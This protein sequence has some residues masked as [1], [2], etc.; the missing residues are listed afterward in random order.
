MYSTKSSTREVTKLRALQ[1]DSELQRHEAERRRREG[2]GQDRLG[3]DAFSV[4][5]HP[6]TTT[7]SRYTR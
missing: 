2:R 7:K 1:S 3:Q 6:A 5:S 4:P